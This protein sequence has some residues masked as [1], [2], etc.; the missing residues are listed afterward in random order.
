MSTDVR[1]DQPTSAPEEAGTPALPRSGLDRRQFLGG[2]GTVTL[3]SLAGGLTTAGVGSVLLPSPA[4]AVEL[5][6]QDPQQRRAASFTLRVHAAEDE[7]QRPVGVHPTNGDEENFP[8]FIGN[9]HKTLPHNAL[10]EVDPAAYQTL[11]AAMASGDVLDF[12]AVPAGVPG[13]RLLNPV[14]G[15][16][17][18]LEGADSP[19]IGVNPPPSVAS[20]ELAAQ[21]AELYWM[22]LLRDVPFAEYDSDPL[23][24]AAA[25][26]LSGMPGY[27]GPRDASGNVTPQLLF[28][29]G[30]P[31][32]TVGPIVSQFLL[33]SFFYDAIPVEPRMRTDVQGLDFLTRFDDWLLAQN[34]G[35]PEGNIVSDPTLR[36]IRSVRDMGRLAGSDRIYSSYFRAAISGVGPTDAANPYNSLER[37]A[38]FATFGLA[39][40][41]G[42]V[43]FIHKAER[44]TWYQKWNVHRFLRPEAFG[45]LVHN[46]VTG[47]ASYPIHQDLLDSPVL[48]LIFEYNRLQNLNRFNEDQG[49]FLLPLMF[50]AGGPTHPA[51]PAGHAVSAGACVTLLKAWFREDLEWQDP[52]QP[53]ADGTALEPYTGPPLTVGGELNKLAHNLSVG[54]DMSGVHWRA[55]DVEGN[56]QGEEVA[57]AI[58]REERATYP[59]RDLFGGFSLTRFDG[60][61]ITV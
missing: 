50:P 52:V 32:E 3:G 46:R 37:Q 57:I 38:A 51:F 34:G 58:L 16:A 49:T 22:A 60:T 30:Y 12:E 36:F 47:A 1:L 6:P 21:G 53:N 20:R 42:L 39:H 9:F 13:A 26:D 7:L 10:G 27:T 41:L 35:R 25:D 48:P 45:G 44:H 4:D 11:L 61:T 15:L 56:R 29:L 28:R 18:T 5:S 14:G 8:S 19:A 17:F 31:G 55:D 59:E 23:V 33:R 40:L 43:G 2:V 54:R 24:Q